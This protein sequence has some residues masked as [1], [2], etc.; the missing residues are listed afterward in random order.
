MSST[1][2]RLET[3]V[4]PY[5]PGNGRQA[6]LAE[7]RILDGRRV[8]I[9]PPP[10]RVRV[11]LE[12]EAAEA[13]RHRRRGPKIAAERRAELVLEAVTSGEQQ[14]KIADRFGVST[15]AIYLIRAGK[16]YA[17]V[18]PGLPRPL[19]KRPETTACLGCHLYDG[20]RTRCSLG[21]PEGGH[22]LAADDCPAFAAAAERPGEA[23]T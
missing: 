16:L 21:L 3:R 22:V 13:E 8:W 6:A 11:E 14:Q 10:P 5:L 19:A 12:I 18:L 1:A 15:T 20:P 7:F 17:D 23:S 4:S 2:P 9:T